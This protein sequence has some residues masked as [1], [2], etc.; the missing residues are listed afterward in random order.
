MVAFL[1]AERGSGLS[2]NTLDLCRA[3]IRYLHFIAGCAVPTAEAQVA[4]TMAGIHRDAVTRGHTPAKN[5]PSLSTSC[6][7]S[8]RRSARP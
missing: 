6:G 2:V 3:A 4:E 8:W 5:S 1:A 7:R